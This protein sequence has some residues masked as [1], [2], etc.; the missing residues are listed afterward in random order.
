INYLE[1]TLKDIA[2][3][4]AIEGTSLD[5]RVRRLFRPLKLGEE[6][7]STDERGIV[8]VPIE[9]GIPGIDGDLIIEAVLS[10]N[11]DY[12]NVI[13]WIE[14]PVGIPIVEDSSFDDRALWGPRN[15]TP[16]FILIFTYG[17][18]LGIFGI[19]IYLVTNLIRIKNAQ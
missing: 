10:D 3:D 11:D 2:K 5:I 8:I 17:L 18:I 6:F 12:G 9:E 16:V 15:R 1:A 4:S 13:A 7:N 14:A 19:V